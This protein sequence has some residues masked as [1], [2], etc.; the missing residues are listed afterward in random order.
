MAACSPCLAFRQCVPG[1]CRTYLADW[2]RTTRICDTLFVLSVHHQHM[3]HIFG[4]LAGYAMQG[5]QQ[6]SAVWGQVVWPD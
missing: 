2:Q 4:C 5:Q 3:Q 1:T 6:P